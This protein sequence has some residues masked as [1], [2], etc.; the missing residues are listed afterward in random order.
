MEKDLTN[1]LNLDEVAEILE[2]KYKYSSDGEEKCIISLVDFYNKHKVLS[3]DINAKRS[4]VYNTIDSELNY[5]EILTAD[6]ARA[7]MIVDLHLGDTIA[8]MQHNL[9]KAREEWYL[10]AKPH[11]NAMAYIR[12]VCALGVRMG[13]VFGMPLREIDVIPV[14]ET[15]D[16]PF[17]FTARCTV[18]R[19]D[20]KPKV[21]ECE[22]IDECKKGNK[23]LCNCSV[24]RL[25]SEDE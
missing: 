11:T 18:G 5:Q 22:K 8:A 9:N 2:T 17:N 25:K 4:L 7:D 10:T 15:L 19:C 12:K 16:C 23:M 1:D 6:K 20:C 3:N 24:I 13:M 14:K 21:V